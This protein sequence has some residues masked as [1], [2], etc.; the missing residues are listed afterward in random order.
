[1]FLISSSLKPPDHFSLDFYTGLSV[2]GVLSISSNAFTLLNKMAAMPICGKKNKKVKIKL[3]ILLLQN[4]ES[5]VSSNND[6]G[7]TFDLFTAW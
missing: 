2:E 1:M 5:K 7:M 3:K 6:P 4:Q